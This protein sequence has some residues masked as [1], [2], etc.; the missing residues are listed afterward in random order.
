LLA[1]AVRVAAKAAPTE[2]ALTEGTPRER[3]QLAGDASFVVVRGISRDL[4][5]QAIAEHLLKSDSRADAVVI[6][7]RDGIILDN[8]FERVGL[9][10]AGF[11]HHSQFR[12]V[13]QVLKLCLGLVWEPISPHLLLQVLIHPVGPLPAHARSTLAEAVANEPGIGGTAWRDALTTIAERMQSKFGRSRADTQKLRDDIAYW[14]EC[15]RFAPDTGAPITL[16][17]ERAQRCANWL[18]LKLH[19]IESES[20]AVLYAAA[21][22][23]AEA[24]VTNLGSLAR[25]GNA[26]I[27]RIA[28]ER[29]VDEVGGHL[30]DPSTFAQAGHGRATTEPGAITS[31]WHTVVWW[32]LAAHVPT[33]TYPWSDAELAELRAAGVDL[34]SVDERIRRRMR[35]WLRPIQNAQS[36]LILVIHDRDEGHHPLW[37]R[38]T[39]LFAGFAEVRIDDALLIDTGARSIPAL[40]IPTAPLPLKPLPRPKRWWELPKGTR[41]APRETESYSSLNKLIYFPHEWVLNYAAHLRPGRAADLAS[42]NLLYGRLAHRLFENFF[43]THPNGPREGE[44]MIR[45]WLDARLPELIAQEGALLCEP[46]MGVERERVTAILSNAFTRLLEHLRSAG[47]ERA[48]AEHETDA[49]FDDVRL[50]GAIDLVLN[51]RKGREIVLDVKWSGEAFRGDEL[52]ECRYLQLATY[53][54]MRKGAAGATTW[55]YHAYFIVSTGNVLANDTSVFPDA[56]VFSP[57]KDEN[58]A[59]IWARL[60]E[61]YLWRRAQIA[62]GQIE[63]NAEGTE[64]D[65]WSAAPADALDT[66]IDPDPFDDY[67]WLTGWEDGA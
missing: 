19:T 51:D 56:A 16:L 7:E 42:G 24:L 1:S 33:L 52:A 23:Q 67:T 63:V 3:E 66:N 60:R 55:P 15:E 18:A 34:P 43:T 4:S 13:A 59:A 54:Y 36:Q 30:A 57:E 46:G 38:L 2:A 10:R 11:Q 6:A 61:T 25:Q 58:I 62:T 31:P 22:A 41:I 9:P 47:I 20:E 53:A 12:A 17:I 21:Q 64:R 32:D 45:K 8:A 28:L 35:S 37:T 27:E 50:R 5:A 65:L 29:L 26:K 14:L 44:R 40:E 39:S 49:A 48:V